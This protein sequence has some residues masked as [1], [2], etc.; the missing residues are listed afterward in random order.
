MQINAWHVSHDKFENYCT[1]MGLHHGD[2]NPG[3]EGCPGNFIPRDEENAKKF[4]DPLPHN[5]FNE[6][7]L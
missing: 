7:V 2:L 6:M 5:F 4:A 3:E 1:G